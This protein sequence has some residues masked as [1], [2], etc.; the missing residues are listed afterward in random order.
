MILRSDHGNS[1]IHT[2]FIFKTIPYIS[3]EEMYNQATYV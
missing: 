3:E 1:Q 2:S